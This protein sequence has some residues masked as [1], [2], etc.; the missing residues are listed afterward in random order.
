MKFWRQFKQHK[1]IAIMLASSLVAGTMAY[2]DVTHSIAALEK[3]QVMTD[4]KQEKQDDNIA[5]IQQTATRT[6]QKV[7]DIA[8]NISD[9]KQWMRAKHH[10]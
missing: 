4:A 2:A 10:D 1:D 7:N 6:E 8:D 9:M 3:H 5:S